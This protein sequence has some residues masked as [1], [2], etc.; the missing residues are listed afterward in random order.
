MKPRNRSRATTARDWTL[1]SVVS[2][3]TL[4]ML[5]GYFRRGC[6]EIRG[7]TSRVDCRLRLGTTVLRG[8][9]DE[10]GLFPQVRR[11]TGRNYQRFNVRARSLAL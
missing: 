3:T 5:T 4:L 11:Q 9:V 6:R 8:V 7:D 1:M 2:L 10:E